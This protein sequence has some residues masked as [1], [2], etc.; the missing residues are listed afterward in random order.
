L[1]IPV[2]VE[3]ASGFNMS[4]MIDMV[5]QLLI[6]FMV[7]SHFNN[8]QN[9]DLAIPTAIHA[10]VPTDRPDRLAVNIKKDGS[11]FC[12]EKP[13]N[14]LDALK[15][16]VKEYKEVVPSIKVYVRADKE[17]PHKYVRQVMNAMGEL[18]IDDFIFGAFKPGEGQ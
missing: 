15:T 8:M 7:M 12:A 18:G 1:K 13:A 16:M 4:P 3:E 11:L 17:T 10:V 6:F 2:P 14:N 5:F 9:V